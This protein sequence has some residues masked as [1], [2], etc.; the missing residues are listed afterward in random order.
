MPKQLLS[1]SLDEQCEFLYDLALGKMA[2][3]NF[4]GAVHAFQEIVKHN[5]EF[6]D[7]AARLAEARARKAQQ[8]QLLWF[9]FG[10]ATL[11]VF[12]GTMLQVGNDLI[13]LALAAAGGLLG[14]L[15]GNLV[16]SLRRPTNL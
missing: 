16:Q 14:F 15:L 11:F 4:T 12:L 1:G 2:Q 9:V 5:P 10:T 8:G 6:R 13:F 7:A 3:G